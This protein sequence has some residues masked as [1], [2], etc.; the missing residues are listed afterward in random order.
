[1]FLLLSI[2]YQILKILRHTKN[3]TLLNSLKE[4]IIVTK[5][6][7]KSEAKGP[8]KRPNSVS[9]RPE[10]QSKSSVA[11]L[12]SV[13]NARVLKESQGKSQERKPGKKPGKRKGKKSKHAKVLLL[14]FLFLFLL[15]LVRE[16]KREREKPG[17]PGRPGKKITGKPG[18]QGKEKPGKQPGKRPGRPGKAGKR[19]ACACARLTF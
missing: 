15:L 5:K 7:P 18:K 10:T 2:F 3:Y 19:F 4:S 17:R 11:F 9:A 13:L 12:L 8:K 14:L 6:E 16:R 1:M